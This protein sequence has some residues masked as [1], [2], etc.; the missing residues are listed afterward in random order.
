MNIF[1]IILFS[2]M[3][4]IHPNAELKTARSQSVRERTRK[5]IKAPQLDW[6]RIEAARQNAHYLRSEVA[7]DIA[8]AIRDG[9]RRLFSVGEL[10]KTGGATPART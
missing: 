9:F 2:D 1:M 5:M 8:T 10:H 3:N 4:Y 6:N 7:H